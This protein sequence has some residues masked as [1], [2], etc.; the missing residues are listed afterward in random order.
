MKLKYQVLYH[1][2]NASSNKYQ[3]RHFP[4]QILMTVGSTVTV[5]LICTYWIVWSPTLACISSFCHNPYTISY[6]KM[7]F[8]RLG[9]LMLNWLIIKCMAAIL[10]S[11]Q[12]GLLQ[13]L[14][15]SVIRFVDE[16]VVFVQ[17]VSWKA[18]HS[19]TGFYFFYVLCISR[20]RYHRMVGCALMRACWRHSRVSTQLAMHVRHA[21]NGHHIGNR[22]DTSSLH[23]CLNLRSTSHAE[24]SHLVLFG[25]YLRT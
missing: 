5:C 12:L 14:A 13:I 24:H 7:F 23:H 4:S 9:Q 6:L 2:R 16:R 8:Q 18:F 20:L 17:H 19:M 3:W 11:A 1:Q 10:S 22:C 25:L 21:G 15:F